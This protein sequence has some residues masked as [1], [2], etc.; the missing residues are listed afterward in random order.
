MS[1][2]PPKRKRNYYPELLLNLI[3][4]L[5]FG[6]LLLE[7]LPYNGAHLGFYVALASMQALCAVKFAMHLVK[8]SDL[9]RLQRTSAALSIKE[10]AWLAYQF[11][12]LKHFP[13]YLAEM[14]REATSHTEETLHNALDNCNVPTHFSQLTHTQRDFLVRKQR[15]FMG[16]TTSPFHVQV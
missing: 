6:V 1:V 16:N 3:G 15:E 10:R 9:W 8:Q 2:R 7:I 11:Y 5:F 12:G 4:S 13:L 14:H